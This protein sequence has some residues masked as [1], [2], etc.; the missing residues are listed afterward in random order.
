MK[1]VDD[2]DISLHTRGHVS[3]VDIYDTGMLTSLYLY[4]CDRFCRRK[5]ATKAIVGDP[6]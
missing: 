1:S 2:V 5:R 6:P 4:T 3:D